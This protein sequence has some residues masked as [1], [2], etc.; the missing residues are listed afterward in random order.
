M[1]FYFWFSKMTFEKLSFNK[2]L[3]IIDGEENKIPYSFCVLLEYGKGTKEES[4]KYFKY[5]DDFGDLEIAAI[6]ALNECC[7]LILRC[8]IETGNL[9]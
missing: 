5:F 7:G 3:C 8:A 9:L 4:D 1:K 6:G 2:N